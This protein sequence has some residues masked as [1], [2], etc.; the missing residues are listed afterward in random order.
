MTTECLGEILGVTEGHQCTVI[1]SQEVEKKI[2]G[3]LL[4]KKFA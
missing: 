3:F 1:A 4:T 2:G